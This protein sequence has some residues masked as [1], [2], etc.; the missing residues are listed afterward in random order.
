ML[1][2]SQLHEVEHPLAPSHHAIIPNE[3]PQQAVEVLEDDEGDA[4]VGDGLGEEDIESDIGNELDEPNLNDTELASCPSRK[5]RP[6]PTWLLEAFNAKLVEA[7]Q[8]DTNGLLPLYANQQTF[9]Y[10]QK[11]ACFILHQPRFSPP[12]LYNPCIF[13]GI[14][15]VFALR[16]FHVPTADPPS[17]VIVKSLALID[18]KK[19]TI[20]FQS[21]DP[22]IFDV[23]LPALATEFPARLSH[24]SGM[25]STL[26]EWM[27]SCFQ[28]GLGSKQFSDALRVQ[29]LLAHDHLHLQYVEHLALCQE[30]LDAWTGEKYEAFLPFDDMSSRGC[31]GFISGSKWLWDM[32]NSYIEAHKHDFNQHMAMLTAEICAIDHSH[33]VTKQLARVEGEQV[34]TALLT[35]T[36]EKGEI[37]TCNLVATK[38]QLQYELALTHMHQSLSL[39][40]HMH[41]LTFYT[42]NMADKPF[43]E[44]CF[45]SLQ[46]DVVP[47]E[48][49]GDL[50]PFDIPHIEILPK[51]SVLSINNAVHSILDDVPQDEGYLVIG[52]D[53]EWNVNPSGLRSKTAII[54]IAYQNRV[55]IL[56]ISEM[57]RK[58]ELPHQL[59]LLLSHP[60]I[61]KAGW[62][63]DT[64][65][66]CLQEACY[67]A[68]PFVGGLDLA[69]YAKE[70]CVISNISKTG[71]SDLS[72]LVLHKRLDKNVS[73]WLSQ[74]WEE[75]VLSQKQLQ[76]AAK[77]AYVSLQIYEELTKMDVPHPLPTSLYPFLPILLYSPDNTTV[78]ARGQ[79]SQ[80]FGN[81]TFDG[82]NI[83]TTQTIVDISKVIVPGAIITTHHHRPLTSFGNP[84]FSVSTAG[85]FSDTQSTNSE[86]SHSSEWPSNEADEGEGSSIANLLSQDL[87][88]SSDLKLGDVDRDPAST[89]F[90]SE[91][92]GNDPDSWDST[93]HS[94]VL[95]D[96]WH[97]FH[98][99]YISATHGLRKQFTQE[100]RDA[101]FI[102]DIAKVFHTYGPI[103]DPD[104]KKPLFS[105]DNWKTAKNVLDLIKNGYLSDPPGVALYTIIGI[106]K[107]A[108]GLPMYQCARGTNTA[109]GGV[110]THIHSCL[111]KFGV[112]I[113]HIQASLM[114][115]VLQHNLLTGT[116]NS[117]G[118][119]YHG[120]FSI[121]TTNHLQELLTTLQDMLIDPTHI[122]GWVNGN[123]YV[124]T[125]EILGILPI[126]EDIRRDCDMAP[127]DPLLHRSQQHYFLAEMQ[128]TC[129]PILPIHT[130]AEKQLRQELINSNS[131]FSPIS[132]EPRWSDAV[133]IWNS[134]AEEH[135]KVSY[136]VFIFSL[137]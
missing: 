57:I 126:P 48:K 123:L 46:N 78:I 83:T 76:Y 21:W 133:K 101:I 129:K 94:H 29:H 24:C 111:P 109:E 28:N 91:I 105:A 89:A 11:S 27:R 13:Y 53:L 103:L 113:C 104:L 8:Q 31:H 1:P 121:W 135:A 16:A 42:D 69:K 12:E 95:K 112:S 33:K 51:D 68:E 100:L 124:P 117:T 90:G 107:K 115:F 18:S 84:P 102:P 63:V 98:M 32:Y 137:D 7:R 25:S 131:A 86:V 93:I 54:Q 88:N 80:H 40:G 19:K 96:V 23:L 79:I 30:L 99:F 108:G 47:K 128:G 50:K 56:Q 120:H 55:Y 14:P 92:L 67:S 60:H 44:C 114:D 119:H 66:A 116:Y 61:F 74:G 38:A 75:R 36:N 134:K 2:I 34:F 37:C 110:H 72:A 5:R 58:G 70:Q 87:S 64:D 136:K 65:L 127:Y 9:W 17:V 82:L 26:F 22:H 130:S 39:Y 10:P 97:V 4:A 118:Q 49:Y 132:C 77:D 43:L 20:T 122:S 41:P 106:D 71:L 45:P 52:F 15:I 6:L 81:S 62:L 73:E 35:V 85:S 3:D 125:T 59:K